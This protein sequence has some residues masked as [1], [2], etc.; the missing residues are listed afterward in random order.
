MKKKERERIKCLFNLLILL[1]IGHWGT[2]F[3]IVGLN[4][5]VFWLWNRGIKKT[6]RKKHG[7]KSNKHN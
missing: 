3:T 1:N 6:K 7:C 2:I 4:V 5:F